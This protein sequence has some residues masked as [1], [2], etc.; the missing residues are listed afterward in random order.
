VLFG[1][2]LMV[3]AKPPETAS[4]AAKILE[5]AMVMGGSRLPREPAS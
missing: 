3:K 5:T 2:F 1:E 4:N